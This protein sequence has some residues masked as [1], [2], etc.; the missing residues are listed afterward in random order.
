MNDSQKLGGLAIRPRR[1]QLCT[2]T[3]RFASQDCAAGA[4][5][6]CPRRQARVSLTINITYNSIRVPAADLHLGEQPSA[7]LTVAF[8]RDSAQHKTIKIGLTMTIRY[9]RTGPRIS[10]VNR[11]AC[12]AS[13]PS[14]DSAA[15]APARTMRPSFTTAVQLLTGRRLA[16]SAVCSTG[17]PR[18]DRIEA[19]AASDLEVLVDGPAVQRTHQPLIASR[20]RLT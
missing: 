9:W 20:A 2:S 11:L 15:V 17:R 8:W 5:I 7:N 13:S 10:Y 14:P 6:G 1:Q 16:A 12:S 19:A 3:G 4:Y 18:P